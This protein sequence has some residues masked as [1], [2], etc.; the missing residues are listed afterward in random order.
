MTCIV[1]PQ[2][3]QALSLTS[4]ISSIRGRCAGSAPRL[5]FGGLAGGEAAAFGSGFDGFVA[6]AAA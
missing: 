4:T 3:G 2:Q 6:A 1:P 5:R